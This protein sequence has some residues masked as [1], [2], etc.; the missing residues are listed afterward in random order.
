MYPR[1]FKNPSTRSF[2]LF[3][4]RGTGKSSWLRSTLGSFP[5]IDLLKDD[6]YRTLLARPERIEQYLAPKSTWVVIDEVQRVPDILNEVHRLIETRDIKFALSGSSARKLKSKGVNL[7]AGR[8]LTCFLFPLT[9]GELGN[10]F[11][12]K[13]AL[14]Y[15]MLPEVW[16]SEDFIPYLKSYITTYLKEEIQQEGLTR[17][18]GSFSRFLE[19]A[20][21]SQAAPLNVSKVAQDVGIDS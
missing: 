9:I 3:G 19:I 16:D 2:F 17:N 1:I 12:L 13:K 7:L 5:Y 18:L 20:S 6:L 14:L 21:F 10:D 8:A 15:G 11:N 4:P